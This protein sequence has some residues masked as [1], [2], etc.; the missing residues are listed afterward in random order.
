MEVIEEGTRS[1]PE[2]PSLWPESEESTD[3][4]DPF[5]TPIPGTS[6]RQ[7]LRYMFTRGLIKKDSEIWCAPNE[8]LTIKT[9]KYL[10]AAMIG[11]KKENLPLLYPSGTLGNTLDQLWLTKAQQITDGPSVRDRCCGHVFEKGETYYRCKYL[12]PPN[13]C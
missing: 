12:L 7:K 11:F 3:D 4:M 9:I 2:I 13:F 5:E 10:Y 8:N 1:P 6:I